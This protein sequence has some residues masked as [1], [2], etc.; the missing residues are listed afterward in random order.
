MFFNIFLEETVF[1]SIT[2]RF[3]IKF[4][5]AGILFFVIISLKNH[6]NGSIIGMGYTNLP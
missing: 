1:L 4:F 3:H 5:T 2:L 6:Q